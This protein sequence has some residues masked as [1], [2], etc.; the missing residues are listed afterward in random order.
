[1]SLLWVTCLEIIILFLRGTVQNKNFPYQRSLGMI[2]IGAPDTISMKKKEAW[3]SWYQGRGDR[4]ERYR[5]RQET[6]VTMETLN[7]GRCCPKAEEKGECRPRRGW[8]GF[9]WRGS[10]WLSALVSE[11]GNI[12]VF[13]KTGANYPIFTLWALIMH[14]PLVK[15]GCE[16]EP[17]RSHLPSGR[18]L[19]DRWWPC[20]VMIAFA[21]LG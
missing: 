9:A 2:E 20:C 14:L 12:L 10:A 19:S 4:K 17:K 16:D 13:I 11:T 1:M 18:F 15:P 6:G 3:C 21:D 5:S 8:A 7:T